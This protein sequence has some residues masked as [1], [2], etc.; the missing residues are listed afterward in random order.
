MPYGPAT[1]GGKETAAMDA[2]M[3]RCVAALG[4]KGVP[5]S[6]A[7]AICKTQWRKKG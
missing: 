4:R 5:K 6:N 2:F 1:K 3:E 7:I